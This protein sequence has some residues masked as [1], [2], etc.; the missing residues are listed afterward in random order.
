MALS[1]NSSPNNIPDSTI[2]PAT[3]SARRPLQVVP[4]RFQNVVFG[5]FL[6]GLMTL[7]VSAITTVRNLGLDDASVEKWLT[8]FASAWPVTFPTVLIVAPIVRRIV[9]HFIAPTQPIEASPVTEDHR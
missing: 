5:F 6:S 1:A 3:V 7:I 4:P 8:A 2:R 9:S